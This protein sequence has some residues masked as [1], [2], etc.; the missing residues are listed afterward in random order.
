MTLAA[1]HQPSRAWRNSYTGIWGG[2]GWLT[3]EPDGSDLLGEVGTLRSVDRDGRVYH[4]WAGMK[5]KV[6]GEWAAEAKYQLCPVNEVSFE[7]T[8]TER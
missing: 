3:F 2:G 8:T 4:E 7:S 6:C 5:L 1:G